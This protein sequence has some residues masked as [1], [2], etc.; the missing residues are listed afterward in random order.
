[1]TILYV[2]EEYVNNNNKKTKSYKQR[3]NYKTKPAGCYVVGRCHKLK[4][5]EKG[6]RH[7]IISPKDFYM[8]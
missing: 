5:R 8:L 2:L 3:I 1:M 4:G 6:G 7:K